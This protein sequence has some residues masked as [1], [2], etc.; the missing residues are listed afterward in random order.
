MTSGFNVVAVIFVL[1]FG[2]VILWG[3]NWRWTL[4]SLG[5]LY[6]VVFALVLYSWDIGLAAVKLIVG[7]MALA[8][9]GTSPMITTALPSEEPSSKKIFRVV[10]FCIAALIAIPAAQKTILWI[11]AQELIMICG[12]IFIGAGLVQVGLNSKPIPIITGLLLLLAG[13]E[14]IYASIVTS[15]LVA[16]L[17]AVITLGIALVGSYLMITPQMGGES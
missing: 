15:I 8:I 9:L 2:G 7:W 5:V 3:L 10:W 13:F 11:P 17:L 1:V 14:I 16:G 4:L 6:G 12:L